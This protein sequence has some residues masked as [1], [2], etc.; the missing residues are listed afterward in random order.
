MLSPRTITRVPLAASDLKSVKGCRKWAASAACQ[1]FVPRGSA[2][3]NKAFMSVSSGGSM[4]DVKQ[5][6][7]TL[8]RRDHFHELVVL[9][10]LD[11]RIHRDERLAQHVVQILLVGQPV[12]R[13]AQGARQLVLR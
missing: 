10:L 12:Q 6:V 4:S 8:P 9:D 5:Q 13:F 2:V 11:L 7:L 3:F 1:F